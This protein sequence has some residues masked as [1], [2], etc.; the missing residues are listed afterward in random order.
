MENFIDIQ[1]MTIMALSCIKNKYEEYEHLFNDSSIYNETI[2]NFIEMQLPDGSF[3]N[4]Y[5]TALITQVSRISC[6]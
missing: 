1:A 6:L 4:V 2:E 5:T 3:G